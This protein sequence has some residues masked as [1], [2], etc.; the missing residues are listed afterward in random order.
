MKSPVFITTR[1]FEDFE[2]HILNQIEAQF[3]RLK[4]DLLEALGPSYLEDKDPEPD[5]PWVPPM[6]DAPEAPR[7]W[8]RYAEFAAEMGGCTITVGRW[9]KAGKIKVS[10]FSKKAVY[11]HRDEL[12]RFSTGVV[13]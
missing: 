13:K 6:S 10:R 5:P 7:E 11:I 2:T 8:L 1:E 3:V 4:A 12:E 9:V